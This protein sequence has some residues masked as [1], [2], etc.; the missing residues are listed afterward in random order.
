M[1][2]DF[3]PLYFDVCIVLAQPNSPYMPKNGKMCHFKSWLRNV[4]F[5]F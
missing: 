2:V 5:Y 4:P 1:S 3:D